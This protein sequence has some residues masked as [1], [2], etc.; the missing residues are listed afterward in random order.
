MSNF[1]IVKG[2][3][4]ERLEIH[5]VVDC[6]N[7]IKRLLDMADKTLPREH[8]TFELNSIATIE[9][10]V[11]KDMLNEIIREHNL[12]NEV[13]SMFGTLPNAWIYK[14]IRIYQDYEFNTRVYGDICSVAAYNRLNK[15]GKEGYRK[16]AYISLIRH[17]DI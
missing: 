17:Y 12:E 8:F 7:S 11:I 9:V 14:G 3:L 4:K 6:K 2:K 15:K 10:F 5:N 13:C 16:M 1:K